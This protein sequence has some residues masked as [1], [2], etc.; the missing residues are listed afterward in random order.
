MEQV[1]GRCGGVA[2]GGDMIHEVSAFVFWVGCTVYPMHSGYLNDFTREYLSI[3][4]DDIGK[5]E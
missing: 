2:D 1:C 5:R 3:Y 4:L